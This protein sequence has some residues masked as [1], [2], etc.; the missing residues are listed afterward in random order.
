[1][2]IFLERKKKKKKQTKS[3]DF[4][5]SNSTGLI[6]IIIIIIIIFRAPWLLQS[7]PLKYTGREE[8]IANNK[9]QRTTTTTRKKGKRWMDGLEYFLQRA[10]FSKTYCISLFVICEGVATC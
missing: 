10:P 3:H 4:T 8:S 9:E 6:I 7:A 2:E 1:M 5:F